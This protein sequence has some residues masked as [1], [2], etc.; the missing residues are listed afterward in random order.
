MEKGQEYLTDFYK[1]KAEQLDKMTLLEKRKHQNNIEWQLKLLR[2]FQAQSALNDSETKQVE[3]HLRQIE[4]TIQ[5]R[6]LNKLKHRQTESQ[7][8]RHRI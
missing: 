5:D 8:I 3:A 1:L 7:E 6:R 4:R 2:R